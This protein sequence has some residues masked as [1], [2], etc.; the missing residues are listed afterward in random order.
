MSRWGIAH[1]TASEVVVGQVLKA[2]RRD[3]DGHARAVYAVCC[4]E[5]FA[6]TGCAEAL[7]FIERPP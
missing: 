7:E 6:I 5:D 4:H 1:Q 2:Q 3:K